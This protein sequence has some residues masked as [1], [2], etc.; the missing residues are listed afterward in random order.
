MAVTLPRYEVS[1]ER[2]W[3]HARMMTVAHR[4]GSSAPSLILVL[5]VERRETLSPLLSF[6]CEC[7]KCLKY[8]LHMEQRPGG[9][10]CPHS[11]ARVCQ[12][13]E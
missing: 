10:A 4:I 7:A 11:E 13:R 6:F 3:H 5:Q 12:K 8:G 2:R 9:G 1:L